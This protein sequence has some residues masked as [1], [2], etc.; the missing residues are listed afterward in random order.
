MRNAPYLI[1]YG[2]RF[3]G[4]LR[5]IEQMLTGPLAGAFGGVH[6]LPFYERIDGADAGAADLAFLMVMMSSLGPSIGFDHGS[7][8]SP[9]Y[10]A[11]FAFTGVLHEVVI[12]A[13][14]ER[15]PGEHA[16][17]DEATARA[18]MNRQ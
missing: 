8:V 5:G 13:N 1:T 17:A 18:E 7:P 16:E 4:D 9:R 3:A 11:P 12:Q 10:Q 6:I 14:P 15:F 2:D